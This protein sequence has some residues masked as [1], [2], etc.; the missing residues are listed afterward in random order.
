MLLLLGVGFVT[1]SNSPRRYEL[2]LLNAIE[3][4]SA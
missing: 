3:Y 4:L 2:P 1:K